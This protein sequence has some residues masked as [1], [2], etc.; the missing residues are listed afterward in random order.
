MFLVFRAALL[1]AALGEIAK[2]LL[3]RTPALLAPVTF[4]RPAMPGT[5]E[6]FA[7][8]DLLEDLLHLLEFRPLDLLALPVVDILPDDVEQ[9]T[10][11]GHLAHRVDE[12]PPL[13]MP[14]RRG[15]HKQRLCK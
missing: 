9:P 5:D 10:V 1:G 7:I 4:N 2:L 11:A 3:R 8:E 6:D 12:A 13:P 15:P 14:D